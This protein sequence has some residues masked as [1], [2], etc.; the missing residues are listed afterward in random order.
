MLFYYALKASY[1][2]ESHYKAEAVLDD[3]DYL[4][5]EDPLGRVAKLIL[6]QAHKADDYLYRLKCYDCYRP[7]NPPSD[8]GPLSGEV[9]VLLDAHLM[10]SSPPLEVY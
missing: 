2:A 10:R 7:N 3:C 4:L 5:R 9:M 8:H 1:R 6:R